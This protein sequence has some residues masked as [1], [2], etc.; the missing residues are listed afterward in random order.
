[1]NLSVDE[2]VNQALGLNAESRE[3]FLA[4]AC[5]GDTQLRRD[6]DEL[7][8][9]IESVEEQGFLNSKFMASGLFGGPSADSPATG[10]IVADKIDSGE[11]DSELPPDWTAADSGRFEVLG[12]HAT[13]GLG[14]VWVA[15]D[16]Q[17]NR[18]VALK[19]IQRQWANQSDAAQRFRQEAEITGFLEHPG[20]VPV[21]AMG[22]REDG[23]PFYAMQFIR[24]KT[25]GETVAEALKDSG[26]YSGTHLR[27]L[28][29]RL[30]DVCQ[31]IEYAHS[32][33]IVHRDLKPA[34]IMLGAYG[35]TLVVDWGL[36][37]C[38]VPAG[39]ANS[40]ASDAAT[41][42]GINAGEST[43]AAA[44]N[45]PA[46]NA[47]APDET[48]RA[49]SSD[50][51]QTR[52]GT[53]LGTP[54]FMSPEQATGEMDAIG[55]ATDVYGLG[56]TLYF[57]LTGQAPHNQNDSN[58]A[59][60]LKT[61]ASGEL[62]EPRTIRPEIPRALEAIALKAMMRHPER[63]Y[64][65]PARLADDLK[66]FLADES[67]SVLRDPLFD[68]ALRWT[69]Q[70]RALAS[71]AL[72]GIVLT[73]IGIVVGILVYDEMRRRA[74]A[75]EN[76][77]ELDRISKRR[78]AEDGSR[79]AQTRAAV[80]LAQNRFADAAA[81]LGVAL[82]R[83][84]DETSLQSEA[85]RIKK[86]YDR[87]SQIGR[88]YELSQSGQDL[89]FLGRDFEAAILLQQ[90]LDELGIWKSTTWWSELPDADLTPLQRDQLRWEI[91]HDMVDLTSMYV[92]RMTLKLGGDSQTGTPSAFRLMRNFLRTNAGISEAKVAVELCDRLETF[93]P[94]QS[95]RWL[96]GIAEFRLKQSTRTAAHEL[97]PPENVSDG[98]ALSTYAL[99]ASV[100][101][102]YRAWF[103]G[104]GESF[105]N[106][107]ESDTTSPAESDQ[108]TLS[109]VAS[110]RELIVALETLRRVSD[111]GSGNYWIR[112][113]LGQ[114]QYLFARQAAAMGDYDEAREHFELAR[115]EY[116]RCVALRPDA[117]F[118]YADR[119]M[120]A[121][122]QSSLMQNH[123]DAPES[124]RRHADDLVRQ[125]LR[126]SNHAA[127]LRPLTDWVYWH[128]GA[129]RAAVGQTEPA[130]EAFLRAVQLGFDMT[131]T[132]DAP[133]VR[134]DDVRGRSDAFEFANEQAEL[135]SQLSDGEAATAQKR[136]Q[137]FG[138]LAA[139]HLSRGQFDQSLQWAD[140]AIVADNQRSTTHLALAHQI[141]GW[142]SL[143][144]E[145]L[146]DAQT[147]FAIALE[148]DPDSIWSLVGS[149][150]SQQGLESVE[151]TEG[152]LMRAAN[153]TQVPRHLGAAWWETAKWKI[154]Q[155]NVP[156]ALDAIRK[157][158]Q[159]NPACDL[160][161]LAEL[162][163]NQARALLKQAKSSDDAAQKQ[164]SMD[165]LEELRPLA[166]AI[167][168]MP[169]ASVNQILNSRATLPPA[170]LPLLGGDFELPMDRY[171]QSDSA[172]VWQ[173]TGPAAG[174]V[175]VSRARES[176]AQG[177]WGI[178]IRG[179]GAGNS[180]H[181]NENTWWTGQEIPATSGQTYRLQA[182]VRCANRPLGALEL[183]VTVEAKTICRLQMVDTTDQW[184]TLEE[185]FHVPNN[186]K[187]IE[188]VR[189]EIHVH[190]HF[191]GTIELDDI[192]ID[193]VTDRAAD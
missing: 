75:A 167:S 135:A 163:K 73:M 16:R 49:P 69:R 41:S 159:A 62:V 170:K 132:V 9:A 19:Q 22:R 119:S 168:Q 186:T 3:E 115:T 90:A 106:L 100:D 6:V 5:G 65:S 110:R 68:R 147:H 158:R 13:G 143:R 162:V 141:A 192:S 102:Q 26:W 118:G 48:W 109:A 38:L 93:R 144:T 179:R 134:M 91:Y 12:Q 79:A 187:R 88:F 46:T 183:R 99:I 8:T 155:G 152:W 78:E 30:I 154:L 17:L 177:E 176:A 47:P 130:Y 71:S 82:D 33:N 54:R 92:T 59:E 2:I 25:M 156:E 1:M 18:R 191:E 180:N 51:D 129:T 50:I 42:S 35:Q 77:Q 153:T 21:Y 56:A 120:V 182:R 128:V 165:R 178:L 166:T 151:Q 172:M 83:I 146:D 4:N 10:E 133:M 185:V 74:T 103:G 52:H 181:G 173:S 160:S 136:T 66:R 45:A 72:V 101:P 111:R 32:K 76:Q 171:W 80:A 15:R 189:V 94:A 127:R 161:G 193:L 89:S 145:R 105:L 58:V 87:L 81:L 61:I 138:L 28:L 190:D 188:N 14:E 23:R 39:G 149:A 164:E 148:L 124:D 57:L 53:A 70:H 131:G 137:Y 98:H 64:A 29:D 37:K 107:P 55:F 84:G 121:L 157:A 175:P 114:T 123:P 67:V 150:Q 31:T 139:L 11:I 85:S 112:L 108:S 97:G 36:A 43:D 117:P 20:V 113:A 174:S 63:R 40:G 44:M 142:S 104:Y 86:Q 169:M 140:Q 60:L 126:D 95:A 184:Q 116:G 24:G 122:R 96:R 7:L 34:N 125:S 27:E